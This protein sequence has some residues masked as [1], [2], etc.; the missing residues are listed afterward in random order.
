MKHSRA[1]ALIVLAL[2]VALAA[3]LVAL[4][5]IHAQAAPVSSASSGPPVSGNRT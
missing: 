5:W 3:T 1:I 2:V 4:R